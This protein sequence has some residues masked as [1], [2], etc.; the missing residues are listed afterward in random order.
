VNQII[1]AVAA[2]HTPTIGFAQDTGKQNDPVWA[3]IFAAFETPKK[4]LSEQKPDVLIVIY[5]DHISSFFLDHYSAFSLG[6]GESFPVADEGGGARD[7]PPIA[8]HPELAAHIGTSLMAES[9]DMS[10]FQ[11][12][13]LDHGC[14]SPLSL[15][16]AR[17]V[18]D[19]GQAQWPIPIIPL[20]VGVLQFPTPTARRCLD[21]GKALRRAVESFQS[22]N[23]A[24]LRIAILATGGL[25]H[26]VHGERAGFNNPQWDARFLELIEQDPERLAQLTQVELS[27]LGGAEGSEVIMWLVMRGALSAQ[28]RKI[29]QTYT[30]PSMTGIATAIYEN[31][32]SPPVAGELDRHRNLVNRQLAG[33]ESLQGTY[34]Y[35]LARSVK[36]L[37]INK[38][39]H[40]LTN[41]DARVSFRENEEA[42]YEAAQLSAEERSLIRSRNWQ[43][44]IHYGA[45]FF[46]LEKFAAVL[47]LSNLHVYAA[48]RG[49]TLDD[50]LKTRNSPTALYTVGK[51]LSNSY[52]SKEAN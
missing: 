27:A 7:L 23:G 49:Q 46:V 26:Q 11:G 40:S 14:F 13:S 28:I 6:V 29:H 5:N 45:I 24:S 48:M 42:C 4:W 15:L 9:F 25:S 35:T 1:G 43:G 44:L 30:L 31:L 37:R 41:A 50:F 47:G 51:E 52:A 18:N 17:T 22:A 20:Q 8:G 3:P 19:V 2:S 33:A 38:F 21:L 16:L 32:A 10:F 39:L 12:R 36:A 34:P